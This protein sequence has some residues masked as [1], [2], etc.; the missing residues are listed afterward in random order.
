MSALSAAEI[1]TRKVLLEIF[2][3]I[4]SILAVNTELRRQLRERWKIWDGLDSV[5]D[6]FLGIAPFLRYFNTK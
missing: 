3:G 5:G 6:V 4:E 2:A 1:L